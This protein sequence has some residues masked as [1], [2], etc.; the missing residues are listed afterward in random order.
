MITA[1]Y[2]Y[3]IPPYTKLMNIFAFV[4]IINRQRFQQVQP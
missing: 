4:F 1:G 3:E 2:I